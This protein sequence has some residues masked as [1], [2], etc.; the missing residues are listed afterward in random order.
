MTILYYELRVRPEASDS[1][2]EA[3]L[4]SPKGPSY[5]IVYTF[6]AKIPTK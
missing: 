3:S 2:T 4:T 6:G 1:A 5:T